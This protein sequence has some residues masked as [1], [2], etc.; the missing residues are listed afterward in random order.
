MILA[1]LAAVALA[2]CG[3]DAPR[4]HPVGEDRGLASQQGSWWLFESPGF[5]L[6]D[7][8]LTPSDVAGS[9]GSL[10]ML[11]YSNGTQTI[12][13]VADQAGGLL[14][15]LATASPAV[16]EATVDGVAATLRQHPGRPEEGVPPSIG[17]D[18]TDRG[19]FVSFGGPGLSEADLRGHLSRVHRATRSEWEAAVAVLPPP[20]ESED[21]FTTELP[22][23]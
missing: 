6:V 4:D 16:G 13:L 1:L 8:G 3:S 19:V 2:G 18:W 12:Q 23:G 11:E 20:D 15:G 7:G 10:W 21:P 22:P 5:E 14:A 17:A 9:T